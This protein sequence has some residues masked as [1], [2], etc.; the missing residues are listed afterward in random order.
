M[1]IERPRRAVGWIVQHGREG[2]QVRLKRTDARVTLEVRDDGVGLPSL[3]PSSNGQH[4]GMF[5]MRE[6][7]RLLGGDFYAQPVS[8]RGTLVQVIIPA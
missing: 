2:L 6:R 4:L 5:G 1:Q 7:A 8:P 3:P